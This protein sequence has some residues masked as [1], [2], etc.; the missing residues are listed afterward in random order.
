MVSLQDRPPDTKTNEWKEAT[1]KINEVFKEIQKE[2]NMNIIMCGDMN[3]PKVN[4]SDING[5][6]EI[7][8]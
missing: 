6:N 4:W 7:C 2:G 8:N 5:G 1:C 3:F